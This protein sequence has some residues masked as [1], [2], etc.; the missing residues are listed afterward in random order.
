MAAAI[1]RIALTSA[2]DFDLSTS[3]L[4]I[5]TD[6]AISVA[7]KV[8]KTLN[9]WQGSWF[10]AAADGIPWIQKVLA[11]KN[12]DLRL[13]ENILRE[14]LLAIPEVTTITSMVLTYTRQTRTLL[15]NTSMVSTKGGVVVNTPLV[16]P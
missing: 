10:L 9:L 8:R 3:K 4:R 14:A 1:A 12:P 6:P 16:L 11:K 15:I 7:A 5:E 13:I 2:G